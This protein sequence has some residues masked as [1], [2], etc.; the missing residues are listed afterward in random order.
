MGFVFMIIKSKTFEKFTVISNT[1]ARDKTISMKAK[2]L[3]LTLASLPQDWIIFKTQLYE[4]SKDGKRATIAAFNELV[5]AGYI[6]QTRKIKVNGHFNGWDY[7][8][9][10]EKQLS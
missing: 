6:L 10:P 1:V 7:V 2:G 3:F 8:V 9:Y 4:F 5:K